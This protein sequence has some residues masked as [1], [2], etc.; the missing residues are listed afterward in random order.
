MREQRMSICRIAIEVD[1]TEAC[2]WSH[3]KD[4]P[5]SVTHGIKAWPEAKV[6]RFLTA[7]GRGIPPE[8]LGPLY[9]LSPISVRA[10]ACNLRRK[11]REARA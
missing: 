5:I 4:M 7:Y 8:E 6:D 9:G 1:R 10:T 11:L 3:V 2:V